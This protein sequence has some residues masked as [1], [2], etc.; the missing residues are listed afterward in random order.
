LSFGGA[1]YP[2]PMTAPSHETTIAPQ[3]SRKQSAFFASSAATKKYASSVNIKKSIAQ[4][5]L[6]ARSYS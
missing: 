3:R 1:L 6:R 5:S 2:R 4:K